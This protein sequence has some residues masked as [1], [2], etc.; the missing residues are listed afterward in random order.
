[1]PVVNLLYDQNND[2]IIFLEEVVED[3]DFGDP[4]HEYEHSI[5][6]FIIIFPSLAL[7][8]LYCYL[9]TSR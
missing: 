9:L 2:A 5:F 1:M 6:T 8:C 7:F 4:C 3:E